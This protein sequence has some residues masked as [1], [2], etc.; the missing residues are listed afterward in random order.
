MLK[1]RIAIAFVFFLLIISVSCKK[2]KIEK[3]RDI[4]K[5]GEFAVP[6]SRVAA[7]FEFSKEFKN[8]DTI[9]TD[10]VKSYVKH[11]FL[12]DLYILAEAKAQGLDKDPQFVKALKKKKIK[13]MTKLN[14]PLYRAILPE[15]FDV[16][17]K[18]LEELYMRLPYR[19]TIQ[20]I[21]VTS[22]PLADSLYQLLM[23]GAN[24]EELVKK[25]SNDLTSAVKSGVLS[26]YIVAGMAA[27]SFENAAFSLWEKGQISKP[28]KTDF[29]YHILR[30]MAREKLKVGSIDE[31]RQRLKDIAELRAKNV[32]VQN[33]I[34][35]LFDKF[36]L[37]IE[38]RLYP[39][40]LKSF[41]RDDV[42]GSVEEDKIDPKLKQEI[43]I[44][45]DKD[46][47]TLADFIEEYNS[48]NRYERYRLERPEDIEIMA[49]KLITPELMY[50]EGVE[51]GLENDEKYQA[52]VK[53]HYRYELGKLAQKLLIDDA[54]RISDEDVKE[55]FEKH[56]NLWKKSKFK[57]VKQYVRNRLFSIKRNEVAKD[58]LKYLKTKYSVEFNEESVR[59]LVKMMN[60]KKHS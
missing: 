31:E 14:G 60:E 59:A 51:R 28:V 36:H 30:L 32:F 3:A 26:D 10:I 52:F 20:Q 43:F 5:I 21:L 55:Y 15:K 47:W 48:L 9:T 34:N 41:K 58:L 12:N 7:A 46:S 44:R 57:N 11:Y 27:P 42:F 24:F 33:F 4:A 19:L 2:E 38:K 40:L 18:E 6:E 39:V 56:R 8:N 16:S 17:D 25:Y 23:N 13:E 45:H 22:K 50:Y 49:R 54:V 53:Y 29:G 35:S 37:K 1:R